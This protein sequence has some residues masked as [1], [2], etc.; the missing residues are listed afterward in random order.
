MNHGCLPSRVRRR[1]Q[2]V[3]GL[4]V[5]SCATLAGAQEAPACRTDAFQAPSTL[6]RRLAAMAL[7]EHER[8]GGALINEQGA[9]VQ[10]G[11]AEAERDPI[12]GSAWPAW[13]LVWSYWE[14]AGVGLPADDDA[15]TAVKRVALVDTPWSAVFISHVMRTAGLSDAQFRFSA[16]H[17]AYVRAAFA[18][19][20]AKARGEATTYA[21]RACDA[22]A[23]PPRVGDVLCSTRAP[24]D[25]VD[26]FASLGLTLLWRALSM[27]CELVVEQDSAHIGLVGGNVAQTV[28]LRRMALQTNGSGLLW[29]AYGTAFHLQQALTAKALPPQGGVQQLWPPTHLSQQSWSVL[30]QLRPEMAAETP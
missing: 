10:T 18:S 25:D 16:T 6:A 27:H 15:P 17:Q 14:S 7:A 12:T 23:T 13:R 4:C 1:L 29:P 5:L 9:L 30:L 11:L 19:H 20:A 2:V 21:Y 8:M 26:S 24:D 28:V 22:W 3:V